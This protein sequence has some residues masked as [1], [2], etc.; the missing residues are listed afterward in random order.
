M[1]AIRTMA[2]RSEIRPF[3]GVPIADQE[4]V[5]LRGLE[6]L[7]PSLRMMCSTT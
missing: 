3:L 2:G 6:P 5:P 4:M 7:T 1:E